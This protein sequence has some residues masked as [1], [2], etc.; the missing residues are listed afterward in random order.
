MTLHVVPLELA[1]ANAL[2]AALHRHHKPVV[3]HR[4]SIGVLDGAGRLVGAAICGRP[5]ARLYDP[6]DVLE[7]TRCVTDGS[8][9]ACSALYGAAARAAKA[10]GY[11][12]AQTYILDEETGASLRAAG[13]VYDG[14]VDGRQWRHTDGRPRRTDQPTTDKG[15]WAVYFRPRPAYG[16]WGPLAE[17]GE[18][19]GLD[20]VWPG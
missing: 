13:W 11:L 8:R 16:G 4:F 9:N 12:K 3:G 5:V 19:G 1:E 7:V 6:R 17:P 2:V 15:R 10:C 14:A 20:L 18:P